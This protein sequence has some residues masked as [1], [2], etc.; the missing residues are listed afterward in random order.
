MGDLDFDT[1]AILMTSKDAVKCRSFADARCWEVPV[2]ARFSP[3]GAA[4]LVTAIEKLCF[5]RRL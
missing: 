2:V 3:G 1:R 5:S 4:S